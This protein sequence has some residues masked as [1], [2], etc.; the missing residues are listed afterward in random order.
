LTIFIVVVLPDPDGP[1][2]DGEA[3]VV[4]G[5]RAVRCVSLRDVLEGDDRPGCVVH[6]RMI[7]DG[8]S[9]L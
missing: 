1:T 6:R 4:D 9:R 7:G 3:Q 2:A 8:L 5:G